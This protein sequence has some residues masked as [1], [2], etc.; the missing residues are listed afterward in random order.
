LPT[1]PVPQSHPLPVAM[2]NKKTSIAQMVLVVLLIIFTIWLFTQVSPMA[3]DVKCIVDGVDNLAG[4]NP[5]T[6]AG[7]VGNTFGNAVPSGVMDALKI[8]APLI[9]ILA[10]VPAALIALFSCCLAFLT[11][12]KKA[13]EGT[14]AVKCLM[15][16]FTLI[17]GAGILMYI[18]IGAIGIAATS[19]DGEKGKKELTDTCALY[20]PQLNASLVSAQ[21]AIDLL[22]ANGLTDTN[23]PTLQEELD[24]A[25]QSTNYAGSMCACMVDV[26]DAI[27]NFTGPGIACAVMCIF[28]FLIN[29]CQCCMLCCCKKKVAPQVAA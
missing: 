17:C 21:T 8:A 11:M 1:E 7:Q 20:G 27:G 19:S 26:F 14:C 18:T 22:N 2:A 4:M 10:A 6:N 24:A 23:T 12:K 5:S 13:G 29:C 9:A 28:L 16:L 15:L 3:D 25:I